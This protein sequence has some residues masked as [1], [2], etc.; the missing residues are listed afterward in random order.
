MVR[1]LKSK[2]PT[3]VWERAWRI[4]A[5]LY[6]EQDRPQNPEFKPS[7]VPNSEV[8][9]KQD[10]GLS[11]RVWGSKGMAERGHLP[12]PQASPALSCSP[13]S[14]Q[15]IPLTASLIIGGKQQRKKPSSSWGSDKGAWRTAGVSPHQEWGLWASKLPTPALL[16]F[17]EQSPHGDQ[18]K[19]AG[20]ASCPGLTS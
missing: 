14:L 7:A 11:L 2:Q 19:L 3:R 1:A 16:S 10:K 15:G 6:L 8:W 4:E 5:P 17:M 18:D 13:L 9:L 12:P 20:L